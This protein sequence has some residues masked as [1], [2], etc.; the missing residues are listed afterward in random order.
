MRTCAC[1]CGASMEGARPQARYASDACRSRAWKARTGYRLVRARKPRQNASSR[2]REGVTVYFP[3]VDD[4]EMVAHV[5]GVESF[6][7]LAA[8]VDTAVERRKARA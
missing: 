3:T 4:A 6:D 7:A 5:L 2:R 1:G 8:I